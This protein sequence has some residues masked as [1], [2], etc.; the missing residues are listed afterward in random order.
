MN[1][2][3]IIRHD[4]ESQ[5][6][7]DSAVASSGGELRAL[8][9]MLENWRPPRRLAKPLHDAGFKVAALCS[10]G[11]WL[12]KTRYVDEVLTFPE[13]AAR[14]AIKS[15]GHRPLKIAPGLVEMATRDPGSIVRRSLGTRLSVAQ[16][17][18]S[19]VAAMRRP[20]RTL[21]ICG[22]E[23]M[24]RFLTHLVRVSDQ[25]G[26]GASGLPA[27][28]LARL[29]F[30]FGAPDFYDAANRKSALYELA[31][32]IGVRQPCPEPVSTIDES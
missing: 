1:S 19:L 25:A 12:S 31:D 30:S 28:V 21:L 11:N 7:S 16:V 32:R 18:E 10:P 14:G 6:R 2:N 8:I 26:P 29:R 17:V 22:D 23:L 15:L 24:R 13:G 9:L 5:T 27:D 3:D 20:E 4:R